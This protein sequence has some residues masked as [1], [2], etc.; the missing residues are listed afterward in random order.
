M[1]HQV[2]KLSSSFFKKYCDVQIIMLTL[3]ELE[4]LL[5]V[6]WVYK[7]YESEYLQLLVLIISQLYQW[8][9]GYT[10]AR[11]NFVIFSKY[12][13]T[14]TFSAVPSLPDVCPTKRLLFKIDVCSLFYWLDV[15]VQ[16][17]PV[18]EFNMKREHV[19]FY[20]TQKMCHR[21]KDLTITLKLYPQLKA[22]KFCWTVR[23]WWY[24]P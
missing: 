23:Y 4:I 5:L 16:L 9:K 7:F 12:T 21:V 22:T 13:K 8:G 10:L 1:R 6:I 24:L 20:G 11:V 14:S 19:R 17:I 3:S 15:D 18:E 2:N